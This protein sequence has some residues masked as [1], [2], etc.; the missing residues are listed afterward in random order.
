MAPL[1]SIVTVCYNS[2]KTIS[3]T[4]DSVLEQNLTSVEY[5]IIDGGSKDNTLDIINGYKDQFGEKLKLISE[6]DNG[7]YDAMNK[8]IHNSRGDFIVFINSDDYFEK[9]AIRKVADFINEHTIISDSVVYGNSTNIYMNSRG[10]VLYRRIIAPSKLSV[11]DKALRN[12]MCG[13]RHQSM[14]I[15]RKVFQKVGMHNLKY[16][17]HADWDFLIKCVHNNIPMYHLN[18]NLT[19]YSMYGVSTKSNYQERHL[20]RKDNCLYRVI[21]WNC[22]LDCIGPKII[23]K[24]VLGESRWNDFLFSFHSFRNH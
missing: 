12:G 9:D 7:W 8:G 1:I 5:L 18:Q 21:D 3:K 24:K 11:G 14:F 15:G 23:A 22:I 20:L 10:E 4:I 13:I 6:P 17:L 2:E 16:K 19:Y